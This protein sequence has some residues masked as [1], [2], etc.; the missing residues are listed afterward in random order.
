[1]LLR[2][3][4]HFVAMLRKQRFVRRHHMLAVG[5][6]TH[7]QV[8]GQRG[9][10]YDFDH[11]F[12]IRM[13]HHRKRIGGDV[14]GRSDHAAR[15]VQVAGSNDGNF[16]AAPGA[17]FDFLLVALQHAEGAAAYGA[18]AQKADLYGFHGKRV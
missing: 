16:N 9:T 4:K 7:D 3:R 15:T 2:G 5:N 1:M 14:S 12:H 18:Y 17:A 11:D 8:F 6:R 13:V 10:T